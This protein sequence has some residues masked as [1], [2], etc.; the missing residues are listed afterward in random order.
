ML[1]DRYFNNKAFAPLYF[2][3]VSAAAQVVGFSAAFFL[4]ANFSGFLAEWLLIFQLA[5]HVIV[6]FSVMRWLKLPLAW[7][8]MNIFLPFVVQLQIS[9]E[10]FAVC[11][12]MLLLIYLPTFWTRVPYYPTSRPV[13]DALAELLPKDDDFCFLDLGCGFGALLEHLAQVKP[14]GRFVGVEIGPLPYLVSKLRFAFNPR[15]TIRFQ[16]FWRLSLESYDFVY[17]FL[18]PHPMEMLWKKFQAEAKKG[19]VFVTNS[20]GLGKK[21]DL[22]KKVMDPKQS[23]LYVFRR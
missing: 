2:L 4:G 19:A 23:A 11:A 9:W 21:P 22:T 6:V 5:V 18:A 3:I 16:N 14:H 13:Y 17:A 8:V 12:I 15:V 1:A 20:F 7:Q 10:L